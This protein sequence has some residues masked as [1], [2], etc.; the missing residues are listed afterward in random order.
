MILNGS[1]INIF[2][3]KYS[4]K[5]WKSIFWILEIVIICPM[6]SAVLKKKINFSLPCFPQSFIFFWHYSD[7]FVT[8][9]DKNSQNPLI[10]PHTDKFTISEKNWTSSAM[11]VIQPCHR[12]IIL[13]FSVC[14]ITL[15]WGFIQNHN[16]GDKSLHFSS[17]PWQT[18]TTAVQEERMLL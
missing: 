1:L 3:E 16:T 18:I 12:D 4:L 5:K 2:L 8:V 14:L 11:P 9:L 10:L 6:I 15:T 13:L 7:Y 17:F